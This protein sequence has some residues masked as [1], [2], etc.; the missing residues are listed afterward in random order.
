MEK[1]LEQFKYIERISRETRR[2][3]AYLN[4][5]Y[6]QNLRVQLDQL[7]KQR[8]LT[9]LRSASHQRI[10]QERKQVVKLTIEQIAKRRQEQQSSRINKT[11]FEEETIKDLSQTHRKFELLSSL[12]FIQKISLNI[13]RKSSI[14]CYSI[15]INWNTM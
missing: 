5:I 14:F 3:R 15:A 12:D 13:Y 4:Q 2:H 7:D 9:I 10:E 11:P 6:D 8:Q 1:S